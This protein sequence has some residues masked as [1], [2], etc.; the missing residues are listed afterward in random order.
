MAQ[1]APG[2]DHRH[3]AA[4]EGAP[5]RSARAAISPEVEWEKLFPSGFRPLPRRWVVER[6]L[7]WL[8]PFPN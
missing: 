3:C 2:L 6:S 5:T 1:R 4:S 8:R 7:A